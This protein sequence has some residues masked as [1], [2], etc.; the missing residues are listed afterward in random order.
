MDSYLSP[1][2]CV[3]CSAKQL[4]KQSVHHPRVSLFEKSRY[5]KFKIF[6]SFAIE[7]IAKIAVNRPYFLKKHLPFEEAERLGERKYIFQSQFCVL[8]IIIISELWCENIEH[9]TKI[10]ETEL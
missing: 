2:N 9:L 10:D 7:K 5:L 4:S 1:N 8:L 3:R 6:F